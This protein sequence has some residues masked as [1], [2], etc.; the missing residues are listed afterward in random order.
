[1]CVFIQTISTSAFAV[2]FCVDAVRSHVMIGFGWFIKPME[3]KYKHAF[4]DDNRQDRLKLPSERHSSR[5][6]SGARDLMGC[7]RDAKRVFVC[8][9]LY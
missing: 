7:N 5:W 4:V 3:V 2:V 1:M 6:C 9:C 8:V